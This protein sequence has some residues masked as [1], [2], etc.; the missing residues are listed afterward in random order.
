[1][2]LIKLIQDD[3]SWQF[4]VTQNKLLYNAGEML[5]KADVMQNKYQSWLT[6]SLNQYKYLD[7]VWLVEWFLI[8]L[9]RANGKRKQNHFRHSFENRSLL[10]WGTY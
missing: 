3:Q 2:E 9:Y 7:S 10:T 4:V 1:M 8:I 5:S 6:G